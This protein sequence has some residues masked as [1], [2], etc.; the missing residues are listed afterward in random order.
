MITWISNSSNADIITCFVSF[1][2]VTIFVFCRH[3]MT[4]YVLYNLTLHGI[5]AAIYFVVTYLSL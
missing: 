1:L 4:L 3:V 2:K 5:N